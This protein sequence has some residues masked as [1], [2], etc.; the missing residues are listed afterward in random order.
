MIAIATVSRRHQGQ[1]QGK[2]ELKTN[3]PLCAIT[4]RVGSGN[5][6]CFPHPLSLEFSQDSKLTALL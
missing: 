5:T 6:I 1:L 3:D 2:W 4:V